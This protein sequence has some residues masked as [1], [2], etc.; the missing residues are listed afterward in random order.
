MDYAKMERREAWLRHPVLG[1][2]SFDA[3]EKLGDINPQIYNNSF[4]LFTLDQLF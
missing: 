1:D 3:F 2:P 4:L